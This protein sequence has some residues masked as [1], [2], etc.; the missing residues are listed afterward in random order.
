MDIANKFIPYFH[1]YVFGYDYEICA[2]IVLEKGEYVLKNILKGKIQE[3]KVGDETK[4]RKYCM[5]AQYTDVVF[6]SHPKS[7]RAYPSAEDLLK[8]MKHHDKIKTS[9]IATSWGIWIIKNTPASNAYTSETHDQWLK[10][11]NCQLGVIGKYTTNRKYTD[12]DSKSLFLHSDLRKV[13]D[14]VI[15]KVCDT[16]RLDISL[17]GWNVF[18]KN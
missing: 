18:E 9:I 8:L 13:V 2:N 15:R 7:S 3:Y 17:Y 5:L 16:T 1:K 4:T 6:H 11:L 12:G 10:L 14:D